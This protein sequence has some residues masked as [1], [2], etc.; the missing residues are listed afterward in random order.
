MTFPSQASKK[1]ELEV[2]TLRREREVLI[3]RIGELESENASTH[4][5]VSQL[6]G[7]IFRLTSTSGG[8]SATSSSGGS[9]SKKAVIEKKEDAAGIIHS[10]H[11]RTGGGE[12]GIRRTTRSVS[13][14]D[15]TVPLQSVMRSV[16]TGGSSV[17]IEIK[18]GE[19]IKSRSQDHL[20]QGG[21]PQAPSRNLPHH[22]QQQHRYSQP[23]NVLAP[24]ISVVN[25]RHPPGVLENLLPHQHNKSHSFNELTGGQSRFHS[26]AGANSFG[27]PQLVR[28]QYN[29][30]GVL[31][32]G[33]MA[34]PSAE[35]VSTNGDAASK[36]KSVENL[37]NDPYGLP[38]LGLKPANSEMNMHRHPSVAHLMPNKPNRLKGTTSELNVSKLGQSEKVRFDIIDG[39]TSLPAEMTKGLRPN[40]IKPNREKIRAILSMSNVIE[41]QRQLLTTVMENEVRR[42]DL[43]NWK[44]WHLLSLAV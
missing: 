7:E 13:Q 10:V 2:D 43:L 11:I 18:N 29:A 4:G 25:L 21:P 41:L 34:V 5:R 16:A 17:N 36:S 26:R 15:L 44:T 8:T 33:R 32:P 28:T 3:S 31:L 23:S 9:E 12:E 14:G 19:L 30:R 24:A 39:I 6:E 35:G 1:L 27:V 20:A 37:N 40:H 42:Q 38:V 22:Y